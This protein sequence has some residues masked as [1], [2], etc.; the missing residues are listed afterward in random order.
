[1]LL[2]RSCLVHL[3]SALL[4]CTTAT[5]CLHAGAHARTCSHMLRSQPHAGRCTMIVCSPAAATAS[6]AAAS[7]LRATA[8][9]V[10]LISS[11]CSQTARHRVGGRGAAEVHVYPAAAARCMHANPPCCD[12]CLAWPTKLL[13]CT[14]Q[15]PHALTP[16]NWLI[17]RPTLHRCCPCAM[18]PWWTSTSRPMPPHTPFGSWRAALASRC[19]KL[20]LGTTARF[21]GRSAWHDGEVSRSVCL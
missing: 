21:V 2:S 8:R 7:G 12:D 20:G 14:S 1:M 13:P 10:V 11:R 4:A 5:P 18:Q 17:T 3:S 6:V 19:D 16:A 15:L 9:P